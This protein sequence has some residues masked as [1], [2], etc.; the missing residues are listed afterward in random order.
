MAWYVLSVS[1]F[2]GFTVAMGMADLPG[3]GLR[4]STFPR[5]VGRRN[6]GGLSGRVLHEAVEKRRLRGDDHR[7]GPV[8]RQPRHPVQLGELARAPRLR[9]PLHRERPG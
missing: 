2:A 4:V 1:P 9:R 8:Q 6:A 3:D 7:T 5:A